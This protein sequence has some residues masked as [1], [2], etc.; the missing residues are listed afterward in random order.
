MRTPANIYARIAI[1]LG[2]YVGYVIVFL[3][4][5]RL[6]GPVVTVLSGISLVIIGWVLG[7]NSSLFFGLINIPLNIFLLNEVGDR[8][9]VFLTGL[10]EI[11]A[12][13]QSQN[14]SLVCQHAR[15]HP[16]FNCDHSCDHY[17]GQQSRNECDCRR[18][19]DI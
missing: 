14:R 7:V 16:E 19:R 6:V 2:S 8:K 10:S 17:N 3:L 15:I 4:A 11:P 18:N 9:W 5:Y 12:C 1:A 13:K